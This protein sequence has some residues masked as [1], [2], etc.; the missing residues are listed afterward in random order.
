MV[1]RRS[2]SAVPPKVVCRPVDEALMTHPRRERSDERHAGRTGAMAA[3]GLAAGLLLV[4]LAAPAGAERGLGGVPIQVRIVGYINGA[5][6][7]VRPDYT[8]YLIRGEEKYKLDIV[9]LG[10]LQPGILPGDINSRLFMYQYE[11]MLT[12]SQ[13]DLDRLRALPPREEVVLYGY[14][15]FQ[16]GSRVLM[17]SRIEPVPTPSPRD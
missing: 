2:D 9:K 15:S 17:L 4:A 16:A 8:W 12:A 7:G 3:A 5:P 13:A 14:L 11:L 1:D 10:I 6:E